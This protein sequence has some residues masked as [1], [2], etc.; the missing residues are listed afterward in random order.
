MSESSRL[1]RGQAILEK[2]GG[3]SGGAMEKVKIIVH[4]YGA[5]GAQTGVGARS[6]EVESPDKAT[7]LQVFE[8]IAQRY[9]KKFLEAVVDPS[10]G[11]LQ[12]HLQV[13]VNSEP[14]QRLNGL[15]TLVDSNDRIVVMID[16]LSGM[17][18]G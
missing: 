2:L 18:G 7:L 14:V 15:D 6:C 10:T 4:L 9:G 13:I 16:L 12:P 17:G 5:L 1:E 11:K 8:L 3:S